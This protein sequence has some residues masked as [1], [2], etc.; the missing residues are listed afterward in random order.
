MPEESK[1]AKCGKPKWLQSST[2]ASGMLRD[3][4]EGR[5][6]NPYCSCLALY[7]PAAPQAAEPQWSLG[8]IPSGQ[9][10]VIYDGP[11]YSQEL[12]EIRARAEK[13]TCGRWCVANV[14]RGDENVI[15]SGTL[16]IAHI[17][18]KREWGKHE[19]F[20]KEWRDNAEFIAHARTDIPRLLAIIDLL[21]KENAK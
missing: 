10:R 21:T 2:I 11:D 5:I 9:G 19:R 16:P 15:Y 12:A 18:R 6:E 3:I 7:A 20:L 4:D 1:C 17:C 8:E 13:A 14:W